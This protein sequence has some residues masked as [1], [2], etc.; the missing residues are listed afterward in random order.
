MCIRDSSFPL[1]L[2]DNAIDRWF[3]FPILWFVLLLSLPSQ[4][5]RS[6]GLLGY[7]DI[8]HDAKLWSVSAA[9]RWC[10]GSYFGS[11]YDRSEWGWRRLSMASPRV[12]RSP[13]TSRLTL[14]V[15]LF[16]GSWLCRCVTFWLESRSVRL[17]T[18]IFFRVLICIRARSYYDMHRVRARSM[19][20][21]YDS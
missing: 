7:K 14:S 9:R 10:I 5:H 11:C 1:S 6:L 12:L 21:S 3:R 2:A 4:A 18:Q 15:W 8:R 13:S 20:T 16:P 17:S 19:H